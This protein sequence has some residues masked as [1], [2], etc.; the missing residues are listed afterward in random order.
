MKQKDTLAKLYILLIF[1]LLPTDWFSPT[2]LTLREFGAKPAAPLLV[3]GGM[4]ILFSRPFSSFQLNRPTRNA[5]LMLISVLVFGSLAFLVN[6]NL[7][8]SSFDRTKNPMTQFVAQLALFAVFIFATITNAQLF[9]LKSRRD[10]VLS[11]IPIAILFHIAFFLLE[12]TGILSNEHGFLSL[13]RGEAA[14][15]MGRRPTGLMTE[16][17]YF[18][19]FA[20]LYGFP[21]L[22]IPTERHKVKL[23][24]LVLVLFTIA[25]LI[26]AKTVV[27]VIVIEF[28]ALFWYQGK[29][30]IRW[31]YLIFTVGLAAMSAFLIIS[32]AALDLQENLSSVMRIGSTQLA[33]NVAKSGYGLTGIGFGQ[34]HFFFQKRFAPSYMLLS[35]EAYDQM[36]SS[37]DQRASTYNLFARVL[38]ET[39]VLGLLAFLAMLYQTFR[40][41]RKDP[42]PSTLFAVLFGAG[43]LGFLITQD[44]YL[45]P[46]LVVALAIILG[47]TAD[48]SPSEKVSE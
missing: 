1:L 45:Y 21:L 32:N 11:I 5:G 18:G 9:R 34:F 48:S 19:T 23:K 44:P 3:L 12:A 7:S 14:Y 20:A 31:R 40:S 36:S 41:V 30:A 6:L 46:P 15:D 4:A 2:G 8:W 13:F 16:P 25:M 27:P 26:R 28:V 37:A 22:V 39:G 17:S 29:S 33:L 47:R 38:V 24:L 35:P 43:S 42:Q 10:F